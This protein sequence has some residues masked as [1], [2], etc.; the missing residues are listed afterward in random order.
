MVILSEVDCWG[1][2]DQGL[3]GG[4]DIP[5]VVLAANCIKSVCFLHFK[6]KIGI[7]LFTT[8]FNGF[9]GIGSHS[10]K[11]IPKRDDVPLNNDLS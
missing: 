2:G 9:S 8:S 4:E 7:F 10:W 1:C 3:F 5:P 11:M 6:Y